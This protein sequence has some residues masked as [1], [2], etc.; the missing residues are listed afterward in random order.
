MAEFLTTA[1][2]SH[3]IENIILDAK[4]KLVLVSPYLQLSKT[5]YERL[6]D[7]SEHGVPITIVYGK[8]ELNPSQ[9]S[10]LS[11]LKTVSLY[12]FDNLC[13]IRLQ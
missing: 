4:T 5:L 7:C 10:S 1:G 12:Y 3:H 9:H 8:D 13:K 6:K 11:E 2:V